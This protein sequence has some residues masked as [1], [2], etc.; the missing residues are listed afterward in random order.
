MNQLNPQRIGLY[1]GGFDPIHIAHLILA[2]TAVETLQLDRL[3]FMP[4]GGTV[5]YK[6]DSNI[7]CGADRVEMARLATAS[8]PKFEVASYEIDQQQFCFT[9]DTMRYLRSNHP[10]GTEIILLVG[11]DWK[12][13]LSIWKGGDRLVREFTVALFSRPGFEHDTQLWFPSTGEKILHV[14]MPLIDISSS[15]IRERIRNGLSIRY[16]V[17]DPVFHYIEEHRLYR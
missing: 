14:A 12:D 9:L 10:Q 4:S 8:N 3:I 16:W 15:A 6:K 5:H 17:P 7:A 1:G 11:G 2:E 13:K